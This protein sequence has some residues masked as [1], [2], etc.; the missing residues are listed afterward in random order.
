M[1]ILNKILIIDKFL[2]IRY[3]FGLFGH[4][5]FI[6]RVGLCMARGPKW[7]IITVKKTT[8]SNLP[9]HHFWES[10]NSIKVSRWGKKCLHVTKVHQKENIWQKKPTREGHGFIPDTEA[11]PFHLIFGPIM[12][13]PKPCHTHST[14]APVKSKKIK[15]LDKIDFTKRH[16]RLA[17]HFKM[18]Q[19]MSPWSLWGIGLDACLQSAENAIT[20]LLHSWFVWSKPL[21]RSN[22]GPGSLL[23]LRRFIHFVFLEMG[24][25][26]EYD[27]NTIAC[28]YTHWTSGYC[29]RQSNLDASHVNAIAFKHAIPFL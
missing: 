6:V 18:W 21:G 1:P 17:A 24:W 23:M 12:M 20:F 4:R 7:K 3:L 29:S 5:I 27:I 9:K 10:I 11:S 2:I 28:A 8:N 13:R 19:V 15:F 16:H 14:W 26:G 22:G 25:L